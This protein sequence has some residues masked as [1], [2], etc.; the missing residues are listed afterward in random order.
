MSCKNISDRRAKKRDKS[1]FTKYKPLNKN[2]QYGLK[3]RYGFYQI[4]QYN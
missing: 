3:M 1:D 4:K 2:C